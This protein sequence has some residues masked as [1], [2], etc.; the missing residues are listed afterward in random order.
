MGLTRKR[1]AP[2]ERRARAS[3]SE[4]GGVLRECRALRGKSQLRLALDAGVSSRHLSF[5]ESGRASPSRD[6]V[7][8]L[9][10]AL[11]LPLRDCNRLLEAAGFAA[12]YRE[13]PLDSGEMAVVWRALDATL[14]ANPYPTIVID[15]HYKLLIA[16]EPA[17][18]LY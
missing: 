13:S 12:A 15:R 10:Q 9:A 3:K 2:M 4:F 6:M 17:K 1:M 7:L 14:R 16:N 5:L 8:T 11:E 18:R